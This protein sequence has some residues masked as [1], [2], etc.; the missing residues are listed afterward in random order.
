VPAENVVGRHR[1]QRQRHPAHN[2]E[3][4][5]LAE[6]GRDKRRLE[7]E[8]GILG[9][10]WLRGSVVFAAPPCICGS[11]L[12]GVNMRVPICSFRSAPASSTTNSPTTST[13]GTPTSPE[14]GHHC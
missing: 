13:A 3:K 8:V 1:R 9:G 6:L 4:K 5:E 11:A 10:V 2:E 7:M 14:H 12:R